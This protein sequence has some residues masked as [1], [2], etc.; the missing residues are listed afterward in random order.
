MT[1][2]ILLIMRDE[3]FLRNL[4]RWSEEIPGELRSATTRPEALKYYGELAIDI[5]LVDI[6]EEIGED[7]ELI[8]ELKGL[9]PATEIILLSDPGQVGRTMAGL[10][11][12]ATDE[13]TVPFDIGTLR[14]AIAEALMR[15]RARPRK[16]SLRR[17]IE[18]TMMAATFAQAGDHAT[19]RG[20]MEEER[21]DRRPPDNRD[22][23]KT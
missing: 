17:F 13:L 11:A 10:R 6:R 20:M 5:T 1:P 9:Q 8:R 4:L 19:A 14:G 21:G 16:R 22:R 3:I 2:I 23:S 15:R 18:Q 7:I 12:G